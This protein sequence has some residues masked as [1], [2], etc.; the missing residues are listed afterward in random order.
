[1]EKFTSRDAYLASLASRATAPAGFRFAVQP[2]RFSPAERDTPEPLTMNLSAAV[3]DTP[4]ESFAGLFTRNR[5]PGAPV[6]LGR[7]RMAEAKSSGVI[8]NNKI[9]NVCAP[10]GLEDARHIAARFGE[11]AGC[12]EAPLFSA[13]TGIIGW[14]LPTADIERGLPDLSRR[15]GTDGPLEMSQAIMTTDSFPKLRSSTIGKGSIV[16]I[17]KGAGMI[18]P[19]LATLLV[20]LFTDI[21]I[22]RTQLT[23]ALGTAVAGSFNGIS[24]DGD[25][26]TSDMVL[27]FSSNLRPA[28]EPAEFASGLNAVCRALAFDVVR[29]GEGTEHVIRVTV[30]GCESESVARGCAKAV[31]NSPLVKTA[32]CGNDPNVGRI[33]GAIGDYAGNAG[34]A[35]D[36]SKVTVDIGPRRVFADGAF[37]LDPEGEEIVAA[38][39]TEASLADSGIGYPAHDRTV[40]IVIDLGAGTG[41]GEAV[42]SDLTHG[43]V[44]ENADYRS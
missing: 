31:A 27:A 7:E 41:C 29:N 26:S 35:I 15:L 42:G 11:L 40:D 44:S 16:G 10:G 12:T 30:N 14:R 5:F 39:L 33:I 3:L 36:Q 43:Y 32:I 24:V 9:A 19:N 8:V 21:T 25:Q 38:Y 22:S 28:V 23:E 4:T 34:I 2:I 1:M 13:S 6:L 17:A 37:R 20:F 18:E